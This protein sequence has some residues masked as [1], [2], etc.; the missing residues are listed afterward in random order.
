MHYL[1][2]L[3]LFRKDRNLTQSGDFIT[4]IL[5]ELVEVRKASNESNLIEEISDICVYCFNELEFLGKDHN[6]S[7]WG[8]VDSVD[9]LTK[10]TMNYLGNSSVLS[11]DI[12]CMLNDCFSFIHNKGYDFDK[13]MLETTKKI[14]SRK[15]AYC[16]KAGKW[17]KD[18]TQ[19]S[20]EL[21]TP[22]YL[23]CKIG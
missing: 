1:T 12:K 10:C 4:N 22:D 14:N 9:D 2:E 7:D 8:G 20:S 15:G 3:E 17:K 23:L 19:N 16:E 21:Y 5:E 11:G 18:P 13:V 6:P